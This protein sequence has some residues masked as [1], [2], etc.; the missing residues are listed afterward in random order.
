M[1]KAR[2]AVATTSLIHHYTSSSRRPCCHIFGATAD[3]ALGP[4]PL[5]IVGSQIM[6]VQIH[7][8]R[9]HSHNMQPPPREEV[10]API[11]PR[12]RQLAVDH[13]SQWRRSPDISGGACLGEPGRLCRHPPRSLPLSL[14]QSPIDP[15]P[16]RKRPHEP[17][18]PPPPRHHHHIGFVWQWP[19][20]T[21]RGGVDGEGRRRQR[22]GSYI[23]PVGILHDMNVFFSALWFM[24]SLSIG[25]ES[26]IYLI[27]SYPPYFKG[28]E[29]IA[30]IR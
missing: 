15:L 19:S 28:K 4:Q 9:H 8:H 14:H 29:T 6:E 17:A 24:S 18:H 10:A 23:L 27:D 22:T 30:Q 2:H 26:Y 25:T 20:V 3:H 5:P 13:H 7:R 1:P 11:C 21:A 16:N 12:H